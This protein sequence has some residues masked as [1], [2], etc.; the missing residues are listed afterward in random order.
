MAMA[1]VS[2]GEPGQDASPTRA[3][4]QSA[5]IDALFSGVVS[6]LE[7]APGVSQVRLC[8]RPPASEQALSAWETRHSQ[9]LPEDLKSFLRVTDGIFVSWNVNYAGAGTCTV[10]A[11]HISGLDKLT[12]TAS[13]NSD[14]DSLPRH[15]EGTGI[16]GEAELLRMP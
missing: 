12:P 10:G 3:A 7:S 2:A 14:S 1:A 15:K 13:T 4:R 16:E 8:T 11:M 5:R 9:V 6:Y